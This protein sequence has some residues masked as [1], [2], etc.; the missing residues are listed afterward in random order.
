MGSGLVSREPQQ[1]Q[2]S[3]SETSLIPSVVY[4]KEGRQYFT[5]GL[6]LLV[7]IRRAAQLD[8]P[9]VSL[10]AER[11]SLSQC[12]LLLSSKSVFS[13]TLPEAI[14]VKAHRG[15]LTFTFGF[16]WR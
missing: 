8:S 14:C 12:A 15:N 4:H 16:C 1:S 10:P 5:L 11:L 9:F 6:L 7:P 3:R 2:K 13:S